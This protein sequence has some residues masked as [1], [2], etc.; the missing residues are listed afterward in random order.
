[1]ADQ[2]GRV[3]LPWSGTGNRRDSWSSQDSGRDRVRLLGLLTCFW[4]VS[5]YIG[6]LIRDAILASRRNAVGCERIAGWSRGRLTECSV[7]V[8]EGIDTESDPLGEL[9]I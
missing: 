9:Q 5:R 2:D 6:D 1:M 7:S 3:V 4:S 8:G